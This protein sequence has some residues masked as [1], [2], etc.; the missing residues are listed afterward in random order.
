MLNTATI[1][2][3]VSALLLGFAGVSWIAF[4]QSPVLQ[5][6]VGAGKRKA[7]LAELACGLMVFATLAAALGAMS[8]VIG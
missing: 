8:A 6:V 1:L 4:Y 3:W 2:T 7:A 5:P